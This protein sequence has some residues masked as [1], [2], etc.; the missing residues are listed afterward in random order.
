MLSIDDLRR[1]GANV[2]DGMGRCMNDESFYLEMVN[3]TLNEKSFDRLTDA[4]RSGDRK[5]AFE[6]AHALKGITGNVALT[7]L[8][9]LL[10]ELTELLRGEAASGETPID[11]SCQTYLDQVIQLRSSLL[12]RMD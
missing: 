3:M 1:F 4:I 8:Y 7:P 10:S 9:T 2:Q 11:A 12:A 6:A 5:G